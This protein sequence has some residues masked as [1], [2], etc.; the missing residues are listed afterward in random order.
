MPR[1]R[2]SALTPMRD[3]DGAIEREAFTIEALSLCTSFSASDTPTVES[4]RDSDDG[5]QERK[6]EH[7]G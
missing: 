2:L 3:G 1:V 5:A 4:A 7:E 6:D